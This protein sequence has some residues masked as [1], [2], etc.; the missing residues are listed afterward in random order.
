MVVC[1]YIANP[2]LINNLKFDLRIY[3]AVTGVNPLRVYIYEE[4]LTRL[5]T[6]DFSLADKRFDKFAHLTN[7][8]VNKKSDK[9]HIDEQRDGV[10]N[11]WSLA[12]LRAHFDSNGLSYDQVRMDIEDIVVK[13]LLSIEHKLYTAADNCLQYRNNCFELLGFDILIDAAMKPWLLE[14]NLSP[15][16]GCNSPLDLRIKSSLIV[17]LLN[18]VGVFPAKKKSAGI[19][20]ANENFLVYKKHA[21]FNAKAYDANLQVDVLGETYEEVRRS[22]GFK[23]IYPSYNSAYYRQFFEEPRKTNEMLHAT[24]VKNFERLHA[25][26]VN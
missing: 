2:L 14:V 10:G 22:G 11:K 8:A 25:S 20:K 26:L 17:D 13:T 18:L 5:A 6:E 24:V 15:S 16:L 1:E 7:F 21:G 12:A 23:L 9:F 4:G 19:M 3:V